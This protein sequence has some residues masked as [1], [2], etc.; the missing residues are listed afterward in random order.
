MRSIP[1]DF[2]AATVAEIDARLDAIL[3]NED[4]SI[5]LAI[6]SGSRAWGFASPDSDYDCRFLYVRRRRDYLTLWPRRDVIET[7]LEGLLDANG[8]DIAKALRLLVKGNA[9]AIEWLRS[10][11]AYRG[12][13]A[14]RDD[15][16]AFADAHVPLPLVRRHYLHLGR[17]QWIRAVAADGMAIKRLFYILRPAA[18]LRWMRLHPGLTPPMHFQ[19]LIAECD[20]PA[21]VGAIVAELIARK[22]ETR[23]LGLAP[24]PAELAAFATAEFATAEAEAKGRADPRSQAAADGFFLE[25]IERFA[26]D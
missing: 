2:D 22:A 12:N 10:P 1:D 17:Q 4:V 13:Q 11:I 18:V 25:L 23:E 7:P 14:F 5:P 6:E 24:M 19:T 20:P 3:R 9:V 21:T 26:P 16:L 8:W 15:M